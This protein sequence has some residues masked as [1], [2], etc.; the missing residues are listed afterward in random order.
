[1]CLVTQAAKA[2]AEA[3]HAKK[4][5]MKSNVSDFTLDHVSEKKEHINE[6]HTNPCSICSFNARTKSILKRHW[7]DGLYQD[8]VA[9]YCEFC[10]FE[11]NR[12]KLIFKHMDTKHKRNQFKKY[13]HPYS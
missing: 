13:N 9:V 1:M 8:E 11:E 7:T 2:K 4:K 10:G 5:N 12:C 6:V 3:E